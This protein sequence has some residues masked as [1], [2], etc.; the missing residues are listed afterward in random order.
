MSNHLE[1]V[2][3]K[4]AAWTERR[5]KIAKG[6]L[7]PFAWLEHKMDWMAYL[8]AHWSLLKV[9]GYLESFGVLI[10]VIFYFSESG[11]RLKQKHY[12]AWQVINS[13]Q[14]K[15]GN[16]GRIDAL[17]V[18]NADGV[19]L[20]GVDLSS[21]FLV[22]IQLPK[23]NLNRAD[24]EGADARKA[25]MAGASIDDASLQ[26]ANFRDANLQGSSLQGSRLDD[27]DLS[28]ANFESADLSGVSLE[29]SDLRNVDLKG[30]KWTDL[31]TIQGAEICG[32]KNPPPGFLDWALAHGAFK[33]DQ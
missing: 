19:P 7:V 12:Q 3:E 17:E 6:W 5:P 26:N 16:G 29:N 21:A 27:A 18:L 22:G 23:A 10:A 24:F 33:T 1:N 9:L 31:K 25:Q 14:G 2:Q 11:D 20:V 4:P 13:A 28:G 32:V 8:L 15:G 30:V